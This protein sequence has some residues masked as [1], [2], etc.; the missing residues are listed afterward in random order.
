MSPPS[1]LC[2]REEL[3]FHNQ[4]VGDNGLGAAGSEWFGEPLSI[5][6]QAIPAELSWQGSV[7]AIAFSNKTVY[8]FQV[9]ITNLPL[10]GGKEINFS[11]LDYSGLLTV[12]D[13]ELFKAALFQGIGPAKAFGC[14]LL[15]VRPA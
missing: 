7:G 15:L 8:R 14:G 12:T 9:T 10:T 11:T 3:L 4:A 2:A 13:P 6:V 1:A 5:D